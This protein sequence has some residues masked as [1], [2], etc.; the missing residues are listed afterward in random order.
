MIERV[1]SSRDT[2]LFSTG[3]NEECRVPYRDR[4][5]GRFFIGLFNFDDCPRA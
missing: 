5:H 2:R 1:L 4:T 3:P